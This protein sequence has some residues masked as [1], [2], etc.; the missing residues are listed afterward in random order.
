MML[1]I[2]PSQHP[3]V[4]I[5]DAYPRYPYPDFERPLQ[6]DASEPTPLGRETGRFRSWPNFSDVIPKSRVFTSGTRACPELAEG[7]LPCA[8]LPPSRIEPLPKF[9]AL[10]ELC[11]ITSQEVRARGR[12]QAGVLSAEYLKPH[13]HTG[14]RIQTC[15][16][17]T[18]RVPR[19]LAVR[20]AASVQRS[21]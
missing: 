9:L 6:R 5:L 14:I 1:P 15:S 16:G 19:Q 4:L 10:G 3:P 21:I 11:K 18:S 8:L 7:D 20:L 2:P 13:R 17:F 12:F